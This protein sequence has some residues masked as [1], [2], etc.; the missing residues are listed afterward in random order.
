[1]HD[2]SLRLCEDI[3][4]SLTQDYLWW[5]LTPHVLQR[6]AEYFLEA[7]YAVI[8]LYREFS[9]A[10]F[11]RHWSHSKDCFLDFL[12][13]G[14]DDAVHVKPRDREKMLR[15]LRTYQTS[16]ENNKMLLLPFTTITDYLHEL[17]GP[18]SLPS[19]KF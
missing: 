2:P 1:M 13:E 12:E 14:P 18:G 5:L 11:T 10:P 9:L 15:V 6:S 17:Y 3:P 7:G 19:P 16:R 8:F 4:V